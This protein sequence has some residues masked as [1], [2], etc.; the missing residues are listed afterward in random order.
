MPG[1]GFDVTLQALTKGPDQYNTAGGYWTPR[2]GTRFIWA[3]VVIRNVGSAAKSIRLN[4]IRLVAGGR[5]IRPFILDMAS[6]VTMRANPEPS[7]KTGESITRRIIYVVPVSDSIDKVLLEGR[8][9]ITIP[10][11]S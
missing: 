1:G 4:D 9:S 10:H 11:G 5:T 8:G 7:I 3:T 6:A 2:E